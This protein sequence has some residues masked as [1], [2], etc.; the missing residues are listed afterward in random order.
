MLGVSL[1]VESVWSVFVLFMC[2]LWWVRSPAES[3]GMAALCICIKLHPRPS[4]KKK[5]PKE[6]LCIVYRL[7][8]LLQ[9]SS[10]MCSY[11]VTF[12]EELFKEEF[13]ERPEKAPDHLGHQGQYRAELCIDWFFKGLLACDCQR[14]VGPQKQSQCRT[15]TFEL[16]D[17]P[18]YSPPQEM[19]DLTE[20]KKWWPVALLCTDYK[21]LS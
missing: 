6:D 16:Q 12:Y 13:Q 19:E 17:S 8:L 5:M 21:L 15:V 4:Q 1:V 3:L 11:A 20:I 10:D 14:F 9:K 2:F 18:P 7:T